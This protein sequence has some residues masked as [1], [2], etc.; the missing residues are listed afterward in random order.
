[1]MP[2]FDHIL[3]DEVCELVSEHFQETLSR[4]TPRCE[5]CGAAVAEG[6]R[7]CPGLSPCWHTLWER[8]RADQDME[9]RKR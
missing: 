4:A 3:S 1:M 8:D 9:N 6:M 2:N 7:A 5:V